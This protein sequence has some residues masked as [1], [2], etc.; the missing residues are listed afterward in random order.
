MDRLRIVLASASPRRLLLLRQIGLVPTVVRAGVEERAVAGEHPE[1]LVVRLAREKSE[2]GAARVGPVPPALVIGADTAVVLGDR[3][4]GKPADAD[5]AAAMLRDLR[6][7]SH[8]V[9]TGVW[10][11]RTDDGR[12]WGDVESTEVQFREYDDALIRAYVDSGEPR[13]KAGAYAIQERGALLASRIEG[14]WS[15]VVGFPLER[16]PEWLL[17]IGLPLDALL[18]WA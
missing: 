13:G 2:A 8:R 12:C 4:L 15:N 5:D 17:R 1:Q 9:L 3:V 7:R 6:G 16:L 14:S 10:L 18:P 11:L